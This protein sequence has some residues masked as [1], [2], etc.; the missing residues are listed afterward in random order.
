ML[1]RDGNNNPD[2]PFSTG[3]SLEHY[4]RILRDTLRIGLIEDGKR[5]TVLGEIGKCLSA[6]LH[7]KDEQGVE[8]P[9]VPP[10]ENCSR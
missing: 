9:P 1:V 8:A 3:C 5:R 6:E 7:F 10:G 2:F 4:V